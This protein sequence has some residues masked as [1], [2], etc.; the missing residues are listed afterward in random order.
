MRVNDRQRKA[1][2]LLKKPRKKRFTHDLVLTY[3]YIPVDSETADLG[4]QSL[5][6][7]NSWLTVLITH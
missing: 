5:L 4:G 6:T 3:R 7:C 2:T 1:R